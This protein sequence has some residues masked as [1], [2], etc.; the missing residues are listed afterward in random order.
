MCVCVIFVTILCHFCDIFFTFVSFC[1][2]FLY[3][4]DTFVPI[5]NFSS[6]LS[7]S[8]PLHFTHITQMMDDSSLEVKVAACAVL[9][10]VTLYF[11]PLKSALL[12]SNCLAKLVEHSRSA[13]HALRLNA[14]WALK[15]TAYGGDTASKERVLQHLTYDGLYDLLLDREMFVQEQALSLLQNLAAEV[16]K[17]DVCRIFEGVGTERLLAVIAEKL[18]S[19]V[20][21]LEHQAMYVLVNLGTG[22][23]QHLNAIIADKRII[24]LVK[25]F[26]GHPMAGHRLAAV[27]CVINLTWQDDDTSAWR[28]DQLKQV[29]VEGRLREMEADE[30]RDV[31]ERVMTALENFGVSNA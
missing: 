12:A 26:L 31:A 14:L 13:D 30:N 8:F 18:A 7:H 24:E 15:N 28:V 22:A 21:E 16:K 29:G 2:I 19:G 20:P 27:W 3:F 4:H 25:R 6:P 5:F 10:N 11:S 1:D 17:E 23:D 9:C